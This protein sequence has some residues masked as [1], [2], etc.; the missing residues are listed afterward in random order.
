M[1]W[2]A[3]DGSTLYQLLD[4]SNASG[5]NVAEDVAARILMGVWYVSVGLRL[6]FMF[7]VHLSPEVPI[8][9]ML[10]CP[11]LSLSDQPTVDR[12]MQALRL[13]AKVIFLMGTI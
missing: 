10:N 5:L 6:A 3:L 4:A 12:T 13:R 7:T 9:Q 8:Y 11:P 2:D 1:C